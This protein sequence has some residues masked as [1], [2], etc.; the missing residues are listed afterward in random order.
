MAGFRP[1]MSVREIPVKAW[2][3]IYYIVYVVLRV[4]LR[5][6]IGKRR[7]KWVLGVLGLQY[8]RGY[9]V[10]YGSFF[11]HYEPH[12]SK[13]IKNVLSR[14]SSRSF[15]D[16]GAYKGYFTIFAYRILRKRGGFTIVAVEPD[17]CNYQILQRAVRDINGISLINEA[18]FIKDDEFVEFY[19]D[20]ALA[21]WSC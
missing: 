9:S 16:L 18:V 17:P 20:K 15:I 1:L 6:L 5:L 8:S 10:R 4:L 11:P 14:A 12:V 2:V 19:K 13:V 7:R 21:R 3:G